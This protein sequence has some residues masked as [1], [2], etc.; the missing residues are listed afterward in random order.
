ML[1]MSVERSEYR[2][3]KN[4]EILIPLNCY[5][6]PDPFLV[7]KSYLQKSLPV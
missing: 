3:V 1:I 7:L 2:V 6:P 4:R 5:L